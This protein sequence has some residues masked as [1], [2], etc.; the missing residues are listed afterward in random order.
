M[1]LFSEY[2]K[3]DHILA[4]TDARV[5]ILVSL[6]I[7][8]MVLSYK[9]FILP[10]SIILSS[11]LLCNGMK[12]PLKVFLIRFSEPL[13]IASIIVLLKFFFSGKDTLFFIPIN[14]SSLILTGYKD[15]LVEGLMIACR[16]LGAVSIVALMGFSTPFT[17]IIAALSWMR[18]PRGF[19]EI[20]MFAYRYI[21][22]L[23]EEAIVI[24]N[25]QKNRLGYSNMRLGLSSFGQ[26]T[27]SLILKAFDH[28]HNITI[29]MIQRGYDG[30]ILMLK[31]KPFKIS[32]I[33]VSILI[34]TLIGFIWKI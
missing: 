17:E 2:Y 13:F 19:I 7:L 10:L 32:E 25:A 6:A 24:Y 15:G 5:K 21:F 22:V 16:I 33:I 9:G 23:L 14:S 3:K 8:V 18:V 12:I 1:E 34:I 31:Q 30:N 20:L 26:L 4:K 11:F 28:S 29:S 27:G